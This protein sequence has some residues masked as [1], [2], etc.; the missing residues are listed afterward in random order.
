MISNHINLTFEYFES[1]TI[2]Y[3]FNNLMIVTLRHGD[4]NSLFLCRRIPTGNGTAKLLAVIYWRRRRPTV[5]VW[6]PCFESGQ[7]DVTGYGCWTVE[8]WTVSRLS[9]RSARLSC[10]CSIWELIKWWVFYFIINI[11]LYFGVTVSWIYYHIFF[12]NL[13]IFFSNII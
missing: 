10:W 13:L 2:I 5:P 7:T 12:L 9:R 1:F 11:S 4:W 6:Y 3:Y 8:S